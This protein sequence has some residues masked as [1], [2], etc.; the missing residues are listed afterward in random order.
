MVGTFEKLMQIQAKAADPVREQ[1]QQLRKKEAAAASPGA[2]TD[3][4]ESILQALAVGS[5]TGALALCIQVIGA[6]DPAF[7]EKAVQLMKPASTGE[8]WR[9][10]FKTYDRQRERIQVAAA[11]DEPSEAA[12]PVFQEAGQECA[13]IYN[14]GGNIAQ[15][16]AMA[17]YEALNRD[18]KDTVSLRNAPSSRSGVL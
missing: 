3:Q 12:I 4:K 2:S 14:V 17:V 16:M 1:P 7:T 11:A 9:M 6:G 5:S 13:R 8:A 15:E 18:Y 10:A